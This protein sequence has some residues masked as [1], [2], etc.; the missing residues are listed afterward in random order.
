MLR[1]KIW[2]SSRQLF[3]EESLTQVHS[4]PGDPE[5][6]SSWPRMPL[7]PGNLITLSSKLTIYPKQVKGWEN[8]RFAFLGS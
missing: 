8:R 5:K 2:W 3:L 6:R 1:I 7:F 4:N